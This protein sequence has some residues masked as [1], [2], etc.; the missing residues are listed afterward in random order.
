MLRYEYPASAV[1]FKKLLEGSN[2]ISP[3]PLLKDPAGKE[4]MYNICPTTHCRSYIVAKVGDRY[5]VSKGNGLSY[6]KYTFLNTREFGDDT[7][8]LLLEQDAVRDFNTGNEVA[9]LGI[10]TNRMEYVLSLDRV[11]TLPS[12]NAV[13]PVLLQYDVACPYRIADARFMTDD[14]IRAEVVKWKSLSSSRFTENH[15][16]AADV[17]AHNLRILH[18]NGILHNAIHSGN[19]TWALELLDFE[20]THTPSF[21]YQQEDYRRHVVTLMPREIFQTYTIIV[22]IASVLGESINYA[23]IDNVFKDYGFRIE[24]FEVQH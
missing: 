14:M 3:Y 15:L 7:L 12:G 19:Y 4:I 24:D 20:L 23:A 13:H 9:S 22:E 8:G 16:I 10:L 2:E 18:D 1:A 21:P 6:T 11:V 5:V 17:M